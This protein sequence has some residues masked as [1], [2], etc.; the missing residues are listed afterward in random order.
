MQIPNH[1]AEGRAQRR[2]GGRQ[3]TVRRWGWSDDSQ[4]VAQ[5]H[6]N[7]RAEA[8]LEQM[9]AK[10]GAA[11][12]REP[13]VAYNGAEGVPIR[14]QVLSRHGPCVITRN[15]YGAQCLNS[16]D[17]F[18]ADIDHPDTRLG[19]RATLVGLM[20]A[21][22]VGLL[23]RSLGHG[24]WSWPMAGLV[25]VVSPSLI[26]WLWNRRPGVREG[27]LLRGVHRVR[28]FCAA[29]PDWRVRLYATP[30]GLR[31][32]AT[33]APLE[34]TSN[35][36][37]QA[38]VELGTDRQYA[39]MCRRQACFRA[40]LTGKPWRMDLPGHAPGHRVAWPHSPSQATRRAAWQAEY[41]LRSARFAA[42]RFLAEIGEAPADDRL[43]AAV[44]L[45]DERCKA[46]TDLSL[47]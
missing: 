27:P 42:C 21:T 25:L 36:V 34:P 39:L 28:Q 17:L 1:W 46:L 4:E 45:H 30:A 23:L 14:E 18:I 15:A 5:Q 13:R 7:E 2:Q 32:L 26:E 6:A 31:L 9:W 19:W 47:A 29:H 10:P 41:D 16:P 20:L 33:H 44:L 12:K 43:T 8:A 22:A 37:Q 40:R 11:V 24:A 38:F 3:L 35:D